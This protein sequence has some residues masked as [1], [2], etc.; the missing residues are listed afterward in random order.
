MPDSIVKQPFCGRSSRSRRDEPVGV[1]ARRVVESSTA[2]AAGGRGRRDLR[3][4]LRRARVHGR[5]VP[6]LRRRARL[7]GDGL[8][9]HRRDDRAAQRAAPRS[10]SAST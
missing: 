3:R 6:R 4:D 5:A 1:A 7:G 2:G 8:A 10:R 9:Q